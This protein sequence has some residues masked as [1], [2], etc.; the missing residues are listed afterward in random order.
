MMDFFPNG[1]NE[2]TY[3]ALWNDLQKDLDRDHK[4][5]RLAQAGMLITGITMLLVLIIGM[6]YQWQIILCPG[7]GFVFC[8][9]KWRHHRIMFSISKFILNRLIQDMQKSLGLPHV[10][11]DTE[12][13]AAKEKA[14]G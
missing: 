3:R 14:A 8:F 13:K 10:S 6:N 11:F 5:C 1:Y 2:E 12:L 4:Y 7:A 9:R